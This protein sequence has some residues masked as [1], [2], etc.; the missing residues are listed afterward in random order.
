MSKSVALLMLCVTILLPACQNANKRDTASNPLSS[1]DGVATNENA[2]APASKFSLGRVF[3]TVAFWQEESDS[4]LTIPTEIVELGNTIDTVVAQAAELNT[5]DP[6]EVNRQKAQAILESTQTWERVIAAGKSVGFL[7]DNAT[8]RFNAFIMSIR[9]E[10]SKLVETGTNS[11]AILALQQLTT[12]LKASY[13]SVTTVLNHG[14]AAY[15]QIV[16]PQ[17]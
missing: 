12:E 4:E 15:Q 6:P 2:V 17:Q 3:R 14:A 8:Q 13:D 11:Q 10:A 9:T 1:A 7:N 16:Q 5:N